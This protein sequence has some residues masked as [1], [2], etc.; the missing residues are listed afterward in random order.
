MV[1]KSF[2]GLLSFIIGMI[3]NMSVFSGFFVWAVPSAADTF[4]LYYVIA[5]ASGRAFLS[6]SSPAKHA[7]CA[8]YTVNEICHRR[9]R[10]FQSNPY[11]T[12]LHFCLKGMSPVSESVF[13]H[14]KHTYSCA[15]YGRD[16]SEKPTAGDHGFCPR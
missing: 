12:P 6:K 14:T 1:V 4:Y 10:V 9:L 2:F 3:L 15:E 5:A 13:I 16:R 7:R 11:R 8:R